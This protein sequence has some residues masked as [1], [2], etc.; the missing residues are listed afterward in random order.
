MDA[1]TTATADPG[2]LLPGDEDAPFDP[3]YDTP[4]PA[5]SPRYL[6]PDPFTFTGAFHVDV[7]ADDADYLLKQH[8]WATA[9][10][11]RD[12]LIELNAQAAAFFTTHYPDSWAP[13]Y[14]HD[15]LGTDLTADLRFTPGY[16]PAGWTALV[17]RGSAKSSCE[18]EGDQR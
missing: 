9:V 17:D 12:R 7:A 8:F 16:A 13:G 15:R 1:P 14:L 2:E 10:V 18:S 6:T 4:P 11:G 3:D 5:S